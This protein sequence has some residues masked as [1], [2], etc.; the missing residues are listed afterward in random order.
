MPVLQLGLSGQ[1]LS[2][3][4][5]YDLGLNFIR[6]QLATV[7]GASIPLPFGG[8]QRNIMVDLD[9]NQ[10]YARH[11]S[12]QDVSN[13]LNQQNL[14]LPTGTAKIGDREYLVALNSSPTTVAAMNDLPIRAANGAVV[15]LKDIAQVR[16]GYV[17]QTN[18]V[19]NNGTRS[20]MLT[21]LKNGQ[22][23][24]LDIVAQVKAALPRV[25]A[26][27]P[28]N[29]KITPLFD[30][31]LFV[32]AS[33][34]GVLREAVIAAV[35]TGVDDPAVPGKLAQHADRLHLDS[36]GDSDFADHL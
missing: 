4:Q 18:I 19:R 1:G 22:A 14:I 21:V 25:L 11:L 6:T 23:S 32:R 31:S 36:A 20:A 27:L 29:L 28:A 10:L 3:Q 35:L 7:Q 8:K 26:G 15:T 9:P 34:Y 2:E 24:T 17:P 13:A 16:D 5:L 12:P 33:I 30:Q